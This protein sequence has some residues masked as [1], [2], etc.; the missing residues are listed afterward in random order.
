MSVKLTKVLVR[1]DSGRPDHD[2]TGRHPLDVR[3]KCKFGFWKCANLGAESHPED[4]GGGA[5]QGREPR[6]LPLP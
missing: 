2:L 3:A 6:R 4:V 1:E 5:K